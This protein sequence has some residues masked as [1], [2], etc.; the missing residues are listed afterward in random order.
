MNRYALMSWAIIVLTVTLLGGCSQK[1]H[2]GTSMEPGLSDIHER[3]SYI[4][5]RQGFRHG[6]M[7]TRDDD[8]DI[9]SIFV[10]VPLDGLKRK[11]PGLEKM[12]T[13]VGTIC[14]LPEYADIT[15]R[16]ELGTMDESDLT[17]MRDIFR[18]TLADKKNAE[19]VT[20]KD[21]RSD[22]TITVTHE[23]FKKSHQLK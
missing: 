2:Q 17:F 15:V 5:R 14:A 23:P 13:M 12:L 10:S 9:D 4:I 22:L 1:M 20:V 6:I 8:R 18:K 11:H 21:S 3:L 16:I 19:V 7:S